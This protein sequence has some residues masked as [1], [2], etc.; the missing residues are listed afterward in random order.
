MEKKKVKKTNLEKLE[1]FGKQGV[2][3]GALK[4]LD[5]FFGSPVPS[6]S[7]STS[8]FTPSVLSYEAEGGEYVREKRKADAIMTES[9]LIMAVAEKV[10]TPE[11]EKQTKKHTIIPD[12]LAPIID[13]VPTKRRTYKQQ[14]RKIL[15]E[16]YDKIVIEKKFP[17]ISAQ[18]F[19]NTIRG[20]ASVTVTMLDRWKSAGVNNKRG[21]KINKEF[22]QE[23][24]GQVII[25]QL[26]ENGD[27]LEVLANSGF[28]REMFIESA[29]A[30]RKTEKYINNSK[31]QA[32]KLS[33]GWCSKFLKRNGLRRRRCTTTDKNKPPLKDVQDWMSALQGFIIANS[34]TP[35]TTF[36]ADETAINWCPALLYQYIP[37]SAARA[38]TPEGDDSGRFTC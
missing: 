26:T 36:N 12:D 2:L 16:A 6:Q 25:T 30:V 21:R 9:E 31:I 4:A 14:F 3:S 5:R 10:F 38:T 28:S 7:L 32:L 33:D 34:L 18:R 35:E 29:K 20:C 24:I 19:I 15:I 11:L 1:E 37:Q 8:S 27:K 23:V 13:I 17:K 22:E